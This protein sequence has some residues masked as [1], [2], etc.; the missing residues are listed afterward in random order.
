MG[1]SHGHEGPVLS[2]PLR[3]R[4]ATV[5][6]AAILLPLAVLTGIGAVALWPGPAADRVSL[7]DPYSTAA[8]VVFASGTVQRTVTEECPSSGA[9]ADAGGT[10]QLCEVSYVLPSAGG[11]AVPVEVPPEIVASTGVQAGDKIRYLDLRGA[12]TGS[13][14]PYVFVDFVRTVPILLLAVVYAAVVCLVARWRGF[15]A[16]LGLVG[17]YGVLSVFMLPAL[18]E[19]KPPLLVGLVGSSMI[20]IAVLYFA[21]G[22]T[23]RTTT[24]LLGTIFGLMV[25]TVLAAWATGAAHLTG[26]GDDASYTLVNQVP[27]L[28]LSGVILCGLL[29]A[30]LGVLNDVTITQSSAVWELAEA[31]P[32]RSAGELFASA[33]RIGRDHIASTV[34]TI[35]FAYAGAALPVLI[36][37]SLYDRALLDTF[38]SGELAEEVIRTLVGS[39]GLVL[40]IPVTTGIAVLV[41]KAVGPGRGRGP[42][43]AGAAGGGASGDPLASRAG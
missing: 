13:A 40:A 3:R 18:V 10:A 31:S 19:G 5:I 16:L 21:H 15:R 27:Q 38:T 6:L 26:V 36:L 37:L 32:D 2:D 41:V 22:F 11:S 4:R 24:A 20:M 35:A 25:T 33:M 39:I 42:G 9:T 29:V 8:G 7:G 30:G 28:S 14:A 17:A 34:Y 23:A 1:H 43:A 12:V